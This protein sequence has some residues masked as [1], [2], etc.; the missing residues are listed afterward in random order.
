MESLLFSSASHKKVFGSGRESQDLWEGSDFLRVP[1][2]ILIE[3]IFPHCRPNRRNKFA[4][5]LE[6][7]EQYG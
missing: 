4:F 1:H 2:N 5:S 6:K 3:L 7:T